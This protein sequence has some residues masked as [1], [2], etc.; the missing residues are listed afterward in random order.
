MTGDTIV[1]AK[2][3][4]PKSEFFA[5]PKP[6]ITNRIVTA[7]SPATIKKEKKNMAIPQTAAQKARGHTMDKL[8]S[9][10]DRLVRRAAAKDS[11]ASHASVWQQAKQTVSDETST[12]SKDPN[13]VSPPSLKDMGG[14]PKSVPKMPE[15]KDHFGGKRIS[16]DSMGMPEKYALGRRKKSIRLGRKYGAVDEFPKSV[17]MRSRKK[18]GIHGQRISGDK[19][20]FFTGSMRDALGRGA[21]ITDAISHALRS[22]K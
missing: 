22:C 16:G 17:P 7:R 9:T 13:W 4:K 8:A 5:G 20:V 3:P 19:K 6:V 10:W 2:K 18:I 11:A 12:M 14:S 1:T 21:T 15:G